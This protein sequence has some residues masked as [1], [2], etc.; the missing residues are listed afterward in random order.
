[1]SEGCSYKEIDREAVQAADMSS[2]EKVDALVFVFRGS[3]YM[4]QVLEVFLYSSRKFYYGEPRI[5]RFVTRVALRS[6]S[7][8]SSIATFPLLPLTISLA[9]RSDRLM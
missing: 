5:L 1:M 7:G 2:S 3:L 9:S 8:T 4:R 6:Q